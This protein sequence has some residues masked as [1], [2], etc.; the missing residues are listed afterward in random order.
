MKSSAPALEDNMLQFI[1]GRS[2]FGKTSYIYSKIKEKVISGGDKII[3]LVPDQSTFETE[4]SLFELLGAKNSGSVSVFGFLSLCRA[5]FERTAN[6]PKNVIDDGTRAVIMSITLEQL[7]GKLTLLSEEKN[8]GISDLM[9]ST[10]KECKKSGV[11]SDMLRAAAENIGDNTVKTKLIETALVLDSFDAIVSQSYID[12]L[13]DLDRVYNILLENNELFSGY[14]IYIDSFSGFTA[15]Q[16]KLVRLLMNRCENTYIAL[17]LDP[18]L[19]QNE[20]V[21]ATCGETYRRLKSIANRDFIRIASPV[22]LTEC[23][24]FKN[25]E[26]KTLEAFAFRSRKPGNPFSGQPKN[27]SVYQASDRYDE[28]EYI[29]RR[30]KRLII[31]EGCLYSDISVICHET[32]NYSGILDVVFEKYDIPYFMDV[33]KDADVKPVIRL[34]NSIFRMI[35]DNFEREDVLSLLKTGLTQCS[36]EDISE[37]EGY[38]YIWNVNN[39]AFKKP[40]TQNPRGFAESLTKSDESALAA[41]ERVR[42]A[43]I[44]PVLRFKKDIKD[45]TGLEI[46]T[47]LYSLMEDMGVPGELKRMYDE[48]AEA[49]DPEYAEEQIRIWE[50]LMDA[51]DKTVAVIGETRLSA[52]RYYELLSKQ[53]RSLDFAEIPRMLDCVTVTTAQR[54]RISSHKTAFV[55][56]CNDGVFPAAPKSSG[57]FSAYEQKLLA[58][59]DLD[60]VEDYSDVANLETYMAYC[61]VT[62]VSDRLFVSYPTVDLK[63]EKFKPSQI[64]AEVSEAFPDIRILD[65]TDFEFSRED[66]MLAKKPA[67][68]EYARSLFSGR[69]LSGLREFFENDSEY[70]PKAEAVRRA[71][72]K[73]PFV[74]ENSKNAEKLFGDSLNISASQIEK[75]SNCPF[76]YFCN[77]GLR[78]RKRYKAEINA[79]E[80][81]TLVHYILELFFDKY[82]KSQYSSMTESEIESFINDALSDYLAGYFGGEEGKTGA[83]LFE[84]KV[85]SGNV[86]V[87]L[88]H[89]IEELSQSDFDVSDCELDISGEIPAYTVRLKNGRTVSIR[90]SVDRVDVME[91]DGSKYLRVVDYKT[92][93]KDFKLSDVLYGVNLQMLIYLRSIGVTGTQK[94]GEIV[95]SGVLY[96]PA[97]VTPVIADN[98]SEDAVKKELNTK[99]KMKGIVLDDKTVIH[100]MDKTDSATYIPVKLEF[101]RRQSSNR[102]SAEEFDAVFKK[103]DLTIEEMGDRLYDGK[104][105]AAPLK[106]AY[107]GCEYCPYDSVCAYRR[108]EPRNAV[109]GIDKEKLIEQLREEGGDENA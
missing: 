6:I 93:P 100:A 15:Q 19:A 80:Y 103:V 9:I 24:R 7:S 8:K 5:V 42:S 92:G 108:S 51:L 27:V 106:G 12:P 78:I 1:L 73:A 98:L 54:V 20:D 102:L 45:K 22:K 48:F 28:C 26:L 95:P 74:L 14:T 75:F 39:S 104:I 16:L 56:G 36:P 61:C 41:A 99:L 97:A 77:Y 71:V 72:Q 86:L 101:D 55:I 3:M 4:K 89:I 32:D 82:E 69:E 11:T 57:L 94:Y 66:T 18:D 23:T 96:M 29:A 70:K 13:D 33:R 88:R 21:F 53:I 43:V 25:D 68:E 79:M 58:L 81:G 109:S 63:G 90:G 30:I 44:E 37:F 62:S 91:K 60:F 105:E 87:L 34:V 35:L 52:K 107:D 59:N 83:F 67:F 40:F 10:L 50:L 85:L 49:D 84:L 47:M 31:D 76:S 65:K 38:V 17:T 2:G 46:S 64:V